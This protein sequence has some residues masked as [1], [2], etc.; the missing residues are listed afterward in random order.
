MDK[1]APNI[2]KYWPRTLTEESEAQ[3]VW[4]VVRILHTAVFIFTKI[5]V[6]MFP[7]SKMGEIFLTNIGISSFMM[8]L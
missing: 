5:D 8:D 7:Y 4:S 6:I 2:Y 1:I 3:K